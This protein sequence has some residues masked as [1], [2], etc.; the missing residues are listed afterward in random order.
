MPKL[1]HSGN[2]RNGGLTQDRLEGLST[3]RGDLENVD[4]VIATTDHSDSGVAEFEQVPDGPLGAGVLVQRYPVQ[5]A[6]MQEPPRS[7][8]ARGRSEMLGLTCEP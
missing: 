8:A 1:D 7:T 4:R 2:E 6:A 5:V 3:G